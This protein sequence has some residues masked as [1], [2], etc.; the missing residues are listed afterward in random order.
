MLKLWEA[1]CV[2]LPADITRFNDAIDQSLA[3]AAVAYPDRL[4]ETREMF[5]AIL[6]SARSPAAT[7][8]AGAYLG[9]PGAFEH[10]VEQMGARLG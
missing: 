1:H 10:Q 3:Q 9:R 8:A 6:G 7:M 2:D 5:P 4:N